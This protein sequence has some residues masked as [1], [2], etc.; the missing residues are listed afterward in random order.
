MKPKSQPY[1]IILAPSPVDFVKFMR[2]DTDP[3]MSEDEISGRIKLQIL[4]SAI[5]DVIHELEHRKI[6]I[7]LKI[8]KNLL[9]QI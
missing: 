4:K 1:E 3:K 9:E 8:I 6:D 7:D 5:F 2:G